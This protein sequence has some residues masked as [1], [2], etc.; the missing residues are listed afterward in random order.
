MNRLFNKISVNQQHKLLHLLETSILYFKKDKSF[1]Y[2]GLKNKSGK[3]K[4]AWN[5]FK[6]LNKKEIIEI[7][8]KKYNEWNLKEYSKKELSQS[9]NDKWLRY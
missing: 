9:F 3:V 6:K 7:G 4:T 8:I 1:L 5:N 2:N